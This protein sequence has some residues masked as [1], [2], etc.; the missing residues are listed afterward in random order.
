M[1]VDI[2]VLF[3]NWACVEHIFPLLSDF[4]KN[5]RRR[6]GPWACCATNTCNTHPF[7]W[8]A[9]PPPQLTYASLF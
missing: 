1:V 6:C 2:G 9:P 3:F 5:D 7:E 4:V 8:I